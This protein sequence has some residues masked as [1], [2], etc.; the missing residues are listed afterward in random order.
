[1]GAVLEMKCLKF[2]VL[3]VLAFALLLAGCGNDTGAFDFQ[4]PIKSYF[5]GVKERRSG[6]PTLATLDPA[7]QA[8]LRAVLQEDGQPI[9][10]VGHPTLKYVNLIAPYGQNGAVQT[11]GSEQ[12][13]TMS[14]R[15]GMLMATRG[16]GAD[17]M[18]SAGPSVA[19]IAAGRGATQRSYY[20]LDGADQSRRF[21][22][23]CTLST[24]GSETI[25][26]LARAY[27][28]RKIAE[29]CRGPN[30]GFTN[31]YWFD[32]SQIMR[33]SRQM[34][35]PGVENLLLQRVID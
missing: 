26:V 3:P 11:W 35:A 30:D 13:E 21:D 18:S 32:Q 8:A 2:A 9:Y 14:L 7:G 19:Q 5:A 34:I 4:G 27:S 15:G 12:Y 28:A 6:V 10:L 29:V 25:T 24:A 22:Y 33:Q 31:E 20:Y 23:T 1:M 17:L 16:F